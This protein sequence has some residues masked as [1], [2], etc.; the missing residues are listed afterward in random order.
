MYDTGGRSAYPYRCVIQCNRPD[1]IAGKVEYLY[2]S[3]VVEVEG[4][5]FC[6][7]EEESVRGTDVDAVLQARDLLSSRTRQ[8]FDRIHTNTA[9][10]LFYEYE[11]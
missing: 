11:P 1:A 10:I 9:E 6:I 8:A 3:I 7:D 5:S 4:R 2:L